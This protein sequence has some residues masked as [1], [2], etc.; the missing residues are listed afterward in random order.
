MTPEKTQKLFNLCPI[1]FRIRDYESTRA[2]VL[3]PSL[4]YYGFACQDGWYDIISDGSQRIEEILKLIDLEA[5]PYVFQVKEKFGS[6]SFHVRYPKNC[7]PEMAA[8]ISSIVS[9]MSKK[10]LKT[11]ELCGSNDDV[12]LASGGR[13]GGWIRSVCVNCVESHKN[14]SE[15]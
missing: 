6:L 5:R 10:S 13:S 8:R 15:L 12:S 7:P 4:M 3:D 1:L 9:E 2:S 14:E 11:C